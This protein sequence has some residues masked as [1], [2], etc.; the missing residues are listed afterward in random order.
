MLPY[1][2]LGNHYYSTIAVYIPLLM[3]SVI[4]PVAAPSQLL[5][6]KS[7]QTSLIFRCNNKN[8]TQKLWIISFN[9]KF[10]LNNN[11]TKHLYTQ[12]VIEVYKKQKNM[13]QTTNNKDFVTQNRGHAQNAF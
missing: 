2:D 11:F 13:Q 5:G 7:R 8:L 3:A 1:D 9:T 10:I 12:Y 4:Y 6:A